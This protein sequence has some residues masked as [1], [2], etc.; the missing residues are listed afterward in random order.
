MIMN[1]IDTAYDYLSEGLNPLPLKENKAP[2]LPKGHNYLYEQVKEEDIDKLFANAFKIGIACGKVSDGF[3]CIDFDAHKSEPISEILEQFINISFVQN[4]ITEGKL[5][6]YTTMSGGYHIYL[7]TQI[8]QSTTVFSRWQ[9]KSVMIEVRANGAYCATYP[10]DGYAHYKGVELIKLGELEDFEYNGL[11]EIAQ[12]FNKYEELI[13]RKNKDVKGKWGETWKANTPDGKYNLEF[14]DEAKE[15]LFRYGWQQVEIRADG[16]EYWVRPNK[17]IKGGFSATWGHQ[18]NM[19]YVFSSDGGCLPFEQNQ[20]YSPFNI[21]TLLTFNGDWKHA[22]NNLR[23]R[24][25][26]VDS[27]EFWS[28]SEKGNYNLNNKRFKLFLENFDYF[29][30]SPNDKS[31]FNFIKKEGIFMDIV[32]EKDLKDF[33][34]N[35]I[36][37]NQAPEGVF[38]LMT[39]HLVY[40]KRE[41]LSMLQTR[42]IKTLK[43]TK[44]ECFIFYQ[45]CIVKI[46]KQGREILSY[47][48]LNISV[49]KDQVI[50]RDYLPFDHHESEYR[51]FIWKISGEDV[52]KYKAFQS[53]IGYLLHTYK[54]NSNNR[55]IIFNDEIISDTPNGRSGKGLFWNALKRLRKVQS[56]DG[57]TFDFNKSFP[58]QNVSTDCQ[59]LVFDDVKKGF[60]FESLFSVITEGITIEYKGK[61]SIKLDVTESPKI[62]ITTNYTISGDSASFNARKYEVEMSSYF[63]EN[64]TPLDEF[65]HELFN[66]WSEEEWARFDNYMMECVQIYLNEGLKTM[67]TK[68]LAYRKLV[69]EITFE[70]YQ[71]CE[72]IKVNEYQNVKKLFD[73]FVL[74]FPEK[75][76]I[77]TQKKLTSN[78]K[79]YCKF[80]NLGFDLRYSAGVGKLMIINEKAGEPEDDSAPF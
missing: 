67:P 9:T 38:N 18:T 4:L 74:Q 6:V 52:A 23:Q 32:Y 50:N 69:D 13:S 10:S 30:T 77:I 62:I 8:E 37:E 15:L 43:D 42:E 34:I 56:L 39:G 28:I 64:F 63:N 25:N 26:M 27:E 35:W 70:C 17:D 22:K 51:T 53:L 73:S 7:K 60:Q 33:V 71:F 49:W 31:T 2:L 61:D 1:L 24:F 11:V 46:N 66:D 80:N 59:I 76:R 16:V 29:K 20:A 57:K 40:F 47:Q 79:K 55:A 45:N 78:I 5:S 58:Y 21:L 54:T 75:S 19:F 41:F 72:G 12:S 3:L 65:G 68:N 14:A 36:E 44:E 48:E